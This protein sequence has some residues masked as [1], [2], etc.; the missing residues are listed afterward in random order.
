MDDDPDSNGKDY[1]I[2]DADGGNVNGSASE[3]RTL[4]HLGGITGRCARESLICRGGRNCSGFCDF[5][6]GQCELGSLEN[7]KRRPL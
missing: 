7:R 4:S 2:A 5:C 3:G 6:N 1:R